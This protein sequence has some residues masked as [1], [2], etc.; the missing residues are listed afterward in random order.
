MRYYV[1]IDP[2]KTGA[3]AVIDEFGNVYE[4]T[5]YIDGPTCVALLEEWQMYYNIIHVGL[6]LVHSM[7]K[8]GVS[9]SFKFGANYGRYQGILDGLHLPYTLITP[10][11]WQAGVVPKRTGDSKKP[12]LTVARQ[13]FPTAEL[14]LVK[15]HGRADA[16]LIA[17]Y[18]RR[19]YGG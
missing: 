2:G 3:M 17:D 7:P 19:S 15:H 4:T 5:D 18:V 10:Q 8:Q 9:S 1:G 6:E 14:H 13:M 12:S 16:L 11:K